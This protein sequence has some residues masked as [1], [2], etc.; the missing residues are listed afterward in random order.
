MGATTD[1]DDYCSFYVDGFCAI[2]LGI[3]ESSERFVTNAQQKVSKQL[4]LQ[5]TDQQTSCSILFAGAAAKSSQRLYSKGNVLAK[6]AVRD[7]GKVK[8]TESYYWFA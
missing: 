7:F 4:T 6:G 8:V 5:Q 2:K 3:F 1:P